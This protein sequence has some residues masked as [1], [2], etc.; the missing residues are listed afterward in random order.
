MAL[1]FILLTSGFLKKLFFI[2]T[3]NSDVDSVSM[4]ANSSS[5][6][7]VQNKTTIQSKFDQEIL[8]VE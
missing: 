1:H 4:M 7:T 6:A 8:E 5:L 2:F 3:I